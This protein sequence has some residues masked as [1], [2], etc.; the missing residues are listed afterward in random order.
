[1]S[2][3]V[4]MTWTK[5]QSPQH[6]TQTIAHW[7]PLVVSRRTI[8]VAGGEYF[9]SRAPFVTPVGASVVLNARAQKSPRSLCSFGPL[10]STPAQAFL[11]LRP[12]QGPTLGE[13]RSRAPHGKSLFAVLPPLAGTMGR[14][15]I[16]FFVSC[17]L[18]LLWL[19][20]EE[21]SGSTGVSRHGAVLLDGQ[22]P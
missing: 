14:G 8:S 2:A 18:T 3:A 19:S 17:L 15:G 13:S 11:R 7:N 20:S 22:V 1:M 12:S 5:G 4:Q 21:D 10:G 6:K 16:C 9:G